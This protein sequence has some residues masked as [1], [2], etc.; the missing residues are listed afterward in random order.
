MCYWAGKCH[1]CRLISLSGP[2]N[3]ITA[4]K[5]SLIGPSNFLSGPNKYYW[6]FKWADRSIWNGTFWLFG[7]IFF[8]GP[9]SL[10]GSIIVQWVSYIGPIF[11]VIG[12]ILG[13]TF[14][15]L[16]QRFSS[17]SQYVLLGRD[18]VQWVDDIGPIY[19][20]IVIIGQCLSLR[21]VAC[22]FGPYFKRAHICLM[23]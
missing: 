6:A 12:P 21:A 4:Q 8:V 14:W 20:I 9:I 10:I 11:A 22:I 3:I 5:S 1:M 19:A 7:L 2:E 16:C 15:L 13:R 17:W 23:G 18:I